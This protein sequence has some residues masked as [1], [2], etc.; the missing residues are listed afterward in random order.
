MKK[1][2]DK[3]IYDR[4]KPGKFAVDI[5]LKNSN[6]SYSADLINLSAG[7]M[8]FLRSSIINKGDELLVKF[9]FKTQKTVLQGEVIRVE[10]REVAVQFLNN[11]EDIKKF[12]DT[13][14]LE[15]PTL[16]RDNIRTVTKLSMPG[17]HED[18]DDTTSIFD[19][20]NE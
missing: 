4:I 16:A 9:P 2:I 8:C 1:S 20:D 19:I 18:S 10:G 14:N 3:R 5:K 12:V 15:F 13:F 11:D 17:H 6:T 7:G